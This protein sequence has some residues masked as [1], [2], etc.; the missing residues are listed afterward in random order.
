MCVSGG[1]GRGVMGWVSGALETRWSLVLISEYG[2]LLLDLNQGSDLCLEAPF[3]AKC[4]GL[5]E[6]CIG[7]L[8][9]WSFSQAPVL[10]PFP[11]NTTIHLFLLLHCCQ[12][13]PLPPCRPLLPRN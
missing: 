9:L 6:I 13:W 11:L 12:D 4:L 8:E 3:P 10:P 5:V 1:L 2:R 7:I